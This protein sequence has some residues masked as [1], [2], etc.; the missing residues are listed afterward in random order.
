MNHDYKYVL[1]MRHLS[2]ETLY[3]AG[4]TDNGEQVVWTEVIAEA[5]KFKTHRAAKF[6][7]Q[8]LKVAVEVVGV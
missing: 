6:E 2:G 8:F 3:F 5:D 7:A 4:Y 1:A